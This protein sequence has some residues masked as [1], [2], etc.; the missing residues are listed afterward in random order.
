[1]AVMHQQM[2]ALF[3]TVINEIRLIQEEAR[4][5]ASTV[6]P[7]WPI[8]ILRTP[9]GWTG[10]K[11]V[12]GKPVEG[13]WRAHQVPVDDFERKPE[14]MAILEGWLKSYEPESLF[15]KGG[16][17]IPELAQLAPEGARRMG[18]N[19]H[20]NGGLLLKDL[21]MPDFRTYATSVNKPGVETTESTRILGVF[22]RDVMKLNQQTANF[23]VFGP[24]ET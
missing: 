14:H 15:D 2:A 22:L 18:A 1:P 17:L 19:P 12:D 9:K 13:T 7:S 6:L 10:P 8:I 4:V 11:F 21:T 16:S 20:G 5:K 23:R 3:D 24:D